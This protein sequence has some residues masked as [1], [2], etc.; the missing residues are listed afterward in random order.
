MMRD[1]AAPATPPR[2]FAQGT[3]GRGGTPEPLNSKSL[4]QRRF[5]SLW[6]PADTPSVP[7]GPPRVDLHG[8]SLC[9]KLCAWLRHVSS[10]RRDELS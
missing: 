5:P 10:R 8:E 3:P 9:K 1:Q 6:W 2:V 4:D 7:K